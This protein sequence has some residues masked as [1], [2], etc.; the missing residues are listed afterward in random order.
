MATTWLIDSLP[1]SSTVLLLNRELHL[2]KC[3][4]LICHPEYFTRSAHPWQQANWKYMRLKWVSLFEDILTEVD[5][6]WWHL[7]W[8]ESDLIDSPWCSRNTFIVDLV[9][10][11]LEGTAAVWNL[12]FMVSSVINFIVVMAPKVTLGPEFAE[13][14]EI[15][16]PYF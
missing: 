15:L 6:L 1:S 7:H 14:G 16:E 10:G 2:C 9:G 12:S 8:N 3:S 5:P 11:Q 4:L 13:V